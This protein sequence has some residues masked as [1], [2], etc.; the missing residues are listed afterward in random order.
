MAIA[1]SIADVERDT[2]LG[3]DTL[4]VWERR[5]GFPRPRRDA[6]GERIYSVAQVDK[7]RAI[8]R[9]M[10]A[11]H[12]PGHLVPLSLPQ[13]ISMAGGPK[14][15]SAAAS[16]SD[17]EVEALM[18]L[19]R[20]HDIAALQRALVGAEAR[21]GLARFVVELVA[22][23]T[24]RV[25]DAWMRGELRIFEEHLF[26]EAVVTVLR[27]GIG[28]LS[29]AGGSPRVL[30]A[31]L[32]GEPHGIGLLMAQA[33]MTVEGCACLPLGVQVPLADIEAAAHE[34]R[35]DIVAL[36]VTGC[37]KRNLVLASL[38]QLRERLP[39]ETSLWVGG[40]A[41]AMGRRQL[42]KVLRVASLEDIADALR[43]WRDEH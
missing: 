39:D 12:R 29:G 32:P 33:L 8:K 27:A 42:D 7:L 38:E 1:L 20:A 21:R 41:P 11:G 18:A 40:A 26:T 34:W 36:S 43:A 5:Y 10:D 3:K 35:A 14:A 37:M 30:L 15:R 19:I 23:L 17:D 6:L 4:R 31:T 9:L 2:G 22:P 13:L 28:S 16:P 24:V 25:G